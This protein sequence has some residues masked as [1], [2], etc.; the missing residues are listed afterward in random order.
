[1]KYLL[2]NAKIYENGAMHTAD[3]LLDGAELFRFS[4]SSIEEN[5]RVIENCVIENKIKNLEK[6]KQDAIDSENFIVAESL[7]NQIEKLRSSI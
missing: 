2:K 7:K 5:T 6:Q 4:S 3:M 1:M